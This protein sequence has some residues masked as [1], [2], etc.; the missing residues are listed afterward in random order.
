MA[1]GLDIFRKARS[2]IT[3]SGIE[4]TAADTVIGSHAF[5]YHVDIRTD[6]LAQVGDVV[7]ETDAG[8][9]HCISGV[10]GH[11]GRRYV[12]KQNWKTVE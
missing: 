5:A 8:G 11:F 3:A 1:K 6:T 4:E 10:F 7:H 2:A 12:H 9:E